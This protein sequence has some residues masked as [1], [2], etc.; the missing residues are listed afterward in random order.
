MEFETTQIE[1]E[2][3]K[4][5]P[6]SLSDNLLDRLDSAITAASDEVWISEEKVIV[7]SSDS[8]LS[9][10][11]EGLRGMV[12]YGVPE[13]MI[14]RLDEAMSRWHEEVPVEE[15]VV[16]IAPASERETS[17]WIG[18]RSVAAVGLL[19]V[20]VA[21]VTS[22]HPQDPVVESRVIPVLSNGNAAPAVFTPNG[23]RASVVAANDHGVIWTKS[24]QPVRCLEIHVNNKVQ[25]VGDR[26]EKLTLE[27]PKREVRFTKVKFD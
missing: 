3:K 15:K 5:K 12:P 21:F 13:D 9:A 24:G 16:P 23:A 1:E 18:L 17:S 14:S 27:Q 26:G 22:G 6:V 8:E 25:F 20:G 11:E 4:L 7:A 10:L 2:L 19:G